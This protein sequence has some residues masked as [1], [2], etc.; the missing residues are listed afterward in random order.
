MFF[1]IIISYINGNQY[2]GSGDLNLIPSDKGSMIYADGSIYEGKWLDGK[3]TW[4]GSF[5]K[6]G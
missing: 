1:P 2:I 4:Y 6:Q 5:D 3:K